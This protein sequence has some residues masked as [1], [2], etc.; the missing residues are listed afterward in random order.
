[1]SSSAQPSVSWT[2]ERKATALG[3]D[4]LS[5]I[6]AALAVAPGIA[7][8][9]QGAYEIPN[10]DDVVERDSDHSA[11]RRRARLNML[12]LQANT[13]RLVQFVRQPPRPSSC[14]IP[15]TPTTMTRCNTHPSSHASNTP[16]L[17]VLLPRSH[18]PAPHQPPPSPHPQLL[19]RR[20]RTGPRL[21]LLLPLR[22]WSLCSRTRSHSSRSRRSRPSASCTAAL[23]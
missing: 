23:T 19:L 18:P 9:D 2:S 22:T 1:M 4:F 17:A 11:K 15:T 12:A 7:I 16:F 5:G 3:I 10:S 14:C 8:I 6:C 21:C 20:P 13:G